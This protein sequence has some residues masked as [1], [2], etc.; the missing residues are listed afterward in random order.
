MRRII[1]VLAFMLFVSSAAFAQNVGEKLPD[2]KGAFFTFDNG[3]KA[4]VRIDDHRL[5]IVFI[6]DKD[7][8]EQT[9]YKRA[10]VRIDRN[11]SNDDTN[12]LMRED[13]SVPYLTHPRFIDPPLS[14]RIHVIFY[15]DEE[16]D[17]G[18]ISFPT[19][20]FKWDNPAQ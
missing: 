1:S 20:L 2:D 7:L 17:D 16:S 11:K 15:P 19:A 18:K 5:Q 4:N 13:A 10:I 12:L 8:V 3:H 14:F 6:D 9:P